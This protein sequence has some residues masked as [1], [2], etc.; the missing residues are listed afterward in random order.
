M[1]VDEEAGGGVGAGVDAFGVVIGELEPEGVLLEGVM[2]GFEETV[3]ELDAEA[4]GV[5]EGGGRRSGVLLE[6]E[7]GGEVVGVLK[8][9]ESKGLPPSAAGSASGCC[10]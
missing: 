2:T 3:V 1:T 8:T 5:I 6:V 9:T 4:G 7:E 10:A